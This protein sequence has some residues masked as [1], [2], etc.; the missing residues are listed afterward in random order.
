MD[1][2]AEFMET[3]EQKEALHDLGCDL[4]QGYL[5]SPAVFLGGPEEK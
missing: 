4:Y 2:L 5:D 1:V 3:E